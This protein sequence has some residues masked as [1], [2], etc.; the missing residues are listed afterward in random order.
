MLGASPSQPFY[1]SGDSLRL[2]CQAEGA[3]QP[4]ASWVFGGDTVPDSQGGS[5][6]LTVVQTSQG[7]VYTCLL[8][9]EKTGAQVERNLKVD[10]YG[11]ALVSVQWIAMPVIRCVCVCHEMP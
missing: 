2:S 5:L 4:S 11:R 9:N 6:N 10:I 3:P 7:G 1:V 8:V